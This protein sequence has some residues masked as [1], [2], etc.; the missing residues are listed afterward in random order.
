MTKLLSKLIFSMALSFISVI[1][2]AAASLP[3][4]TVSVKDGKTNEPIQY[5]TVSFFNANDSLIA[6]GIT[7]ENGYINLPTAT[8][9]GRIRIEYIGYKQYNAPVKDKNIGTVLL[10]QDSEMLQEVTVTGQARTTKIDR[11]IFTITDEQRAGTA[12]SRELLGK[13]NG[14]I[15]N[16]YD[17][18]IMVNGKTNILVL[19]DGIEKDQNMA[20]TLSPQ[21]VDRVEIIKDPVGK[22]AADG[23]SS[24]INIITKKDFTGI[25]INVNANPMTNFT[26]YHLSDRKFFQ[27]NA[28]LNVLYTYKKLNVYG[29]INSNFSNLNMPLE[30]TTQYGDLTVKTPKMNKNNPNVI[31]ENLY[32]GF[33]FGGDY[34]LSPGNT[35]AFEMNYNTGFNNSTNQLDLTT[36]KNDEIIGRSLSTNRSRS[37]NDAIQGTLT[38]I[39]KW[40]EKSNFE[41]D[42]RYRHSMPTNYSMFAQGDMNSTTYNNQMENFYRLNLDYTYQFTP[43]FSINAAYGLIIDDYNLHQNSTTLTQNVV[44]NRPAAYLSYNPTDKWSF[45][46]GAMIEFYNQTFAD[47]KQ[48]QT[49]L[50][51]MANV[52]Y[53]PTANF[54][55][56]AKYTASPGY[57][58]I[59]SMNTFKT[60]QDSLTWSVGNPDLKMSNWQSVELRFNFMKYFNVNAFYAFNPNDYQQYVRQDNGQY[61]STTVNANFKEFGINTS[62]NYPLTKTLYWQLYADVNRRWYSYADARNQ[63]TSFVM[64]SSL[65]Y[66]IPKLDGAAAIQLSK[67]VTKRA[68]LQGYNANNNDLLL[69]MLQKSFMK[70]RL[71]CTL[72]YVTPLKLGN[73]LKYEQDNYTAAPGYMARSRV[74]LDV[75]KNTILLQLNYRFTAGKTIK[76]KK[77]SLGDDNN[78]QKK[79][80][81]LGL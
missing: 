37:T 60:Q 5:A 39:G 45:K 9:E 34:T 6:G 79:S 58:N 63:R 31:S 30:T 76:V 23:Y 61:L 26:Q 35:L 52:M 13:L 28:N 81:G 32:H 54:N 22:Y 59:N 29:A 78:V 19:V 10:E 40:G 53:K 46:A 42:L 18:S 14:V 33:T 20:K 65:Y 49:G 68:A 72:I 1:N 7:D 27:E 24:V 64:S 56:T 3:D 55:V 66:A 8:N 15:Y 41:G 62:F 69:F 77:S 75:L 16:P 38:Y 50:L 47:N 80:G 48:S 25:D 21:R 2:I 12:T 57:P 71:N 4:V 36:Y 11:D 43:K 17:Q 67:F 44:R 73:F 70:K 51:P 74:D